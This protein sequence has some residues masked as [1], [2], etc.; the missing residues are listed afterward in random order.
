[1]S[2]RYIY[3]GQILFARRDLSGRYRTFKKPIGENRDDFRAHT[4]NLKGLG[5]WNTFEGAQ[6]ALDAEA[7]RRGLE[8]YSGD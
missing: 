7:E 6:K 8:V 5:V 1:M 2:K 4:C 3:K